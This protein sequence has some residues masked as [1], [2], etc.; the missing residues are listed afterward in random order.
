MA[1]KVS[2]FVGVVLSATALL[3]CNGA[4]GGSL[5]PGQA[6]ITVDRTPVYVGPQDAKLL[7]VVEAGT[8]LQVTGAQ[9]ARLRVAPSRGDQSLDG[10]IDAKNLLALDHNL[11]YHRA[12]G[13]Q[14]ARDTQQALD[15]YAETLESDRGNSRAYYNRALL[16]RER[17]D[18]SGAIAD[19]TEAIRIDP[20]FAEAY[21]ARGNAYADQNDLEPAIKDYDKAVALRPKYALAYYNR[22]LVRHLWASEL[23]TRQ[24]KVQKA[25][26]EEQGAFEDLKRA[27]TLG[28]PAAI[29][30]RLSKVG[31]PTDIV[32]AAEAGYVRVMAHGSMGA[33]GVGGEMKSLVPL[34]PELVFPVVP[35]TR[36]ASAGAYQNMVS[37]G[38]GAARPVKDSFGK[39]E[40]RGDTGATS[41]LQAACLDAGRPFPEDS[42]RFRGVTPVGEDIQKLLCYV[43]YPQAV[44][45][46]NG[47]TED[48]A[49]VELLERA[50]IQLY[51]RSMAQEGKGRGF[52]DDPKA[53]FFFHQQVR[54]AAVWAVADDLPAKDI[55]ARL[56]SITDLHARVA[57]KVLDLAAIPQRLGVEPVALRELSVEELLKIKALGKNQRFLARI[58]PESLNASL[59]MSLSGLSVQ[60]KEALAAVLKVSVPDLATKSQEILV[61]VRERAALVQ[62]DLAVAKAF[63][64]ELAS[65][66]KKAADAAKVPL[67]DIVIDEKDT[68]KVAF[69]ILG[70]DSYSLSLANIFLKELT[71][72]ERLTLLLA[73]KV[74]ALDKSYLKDL[75][76][77][78]K[79]D[80][81]AKK[82]NLDL[83]LTLLTLVR[84]PLEQSIEDAI[85][86]IGDARFQAVSARR[87]VVS[88]KDDVEANVAHFRQWQPGTSRWDGV[89]F[90]DKYQ[91]GVAWKL[92]NRISLNTDPPP[93]RPGDVQAVSTTSED[94]GVALPV[95]GSRFGRRV[96]PVPR[97]LGQFVE[98]AVRFRN[99]GQQPAVI[100]FCTPSS[101][102]AGA[103][104]QLG[105]GTAVAPV[106]FVL[107]QVGV[108]PAQFETTKD[109]TAVSELALS[110]AGNLGFEIESR[111]ETCALFLFDVPRDADRFHLVI[112]G[113][114]L[115]LGLPVSSSAFQPVDDK[116]IP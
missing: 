40:L 15:A 78:E 41:S 104:L 33:F 86:K 50:A 114:T 4:V 18:T 8:T 72:E 37:C 14:G 27:K 55:S 73:E 90:I 9:G 102:Y 92:D 32:S 47:K 85:V 80:L 38:Q 54:Q 83:T 22:G 97:P 88:L 110:S 62:K 103:Y 56:S 31:E 13:Y 21:L 1:A 70:L 45:D 98:V 26:E 60:D 44:P 65:K 12:L 76:P 46:E 43:E 66:E 10:W 108:P 11:P 101:V 112:M 58:S 94:D 2:S 59:K 84:L 111:Q 109:I 61:L 106:D 49:E 115:D 96:A 95:A 3:W 79:A 23:S 52:P 71:P 24:H 30:K 29:D 42:D 36:F 67:E 81:D 63:L 116:M 107:A 87:R 68:L 113:K 51:E 16:Y 5:T 19:C 82:K 77:E 35:G 100:Q 69:D 64:K 7:R 91:K 25:A 17:G 39:Y 75:V 57:A 99:V 93:M 28:L 34:S 74:L 89:Y 48:V 6:G 20:K 53:F 105:D